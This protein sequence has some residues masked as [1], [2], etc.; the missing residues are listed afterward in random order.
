MEKDKEAKEEFEKT[1][2]FFDTNNNGKIKFEDFS[3]FMKKL[4][5]N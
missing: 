4:L 5:E 1:I 2:K 3:V